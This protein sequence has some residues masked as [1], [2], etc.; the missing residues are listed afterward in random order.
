MTKANP[1]DASKK[2]KKEMQTKPNYER[3]RENM[4][5]F[6]KAAN[7]NKL[8]RRAFQASIMN[9]KDRYVSARLTKRL[10]RIV[11]T[12]DMSRRGERFITS[13]FLRM[14][15]GFNFN[16]DKP[17]THVLYANYEVSIDRFAGMVTIS[18]PVFNPQT[19]IDGTVDKYDFQLVGAVASIDFNEGSIDCSKRVDHLFNSSDRDT[20]SFELQIPFPAGFARPL[21]VALGVE[22]ISSQGPDD[23]TVMQKKLSA[24]SIVRV[25]T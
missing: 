10:S 22:I 18:I 12:D 17:L 8:I 21:I 1:N 2:K 14:L 25:F 19:M 20:R 11:L 16:H 15:E 3:T 6:G 9:A 24:L 5:E 13:K 7:G 23:W 4:A